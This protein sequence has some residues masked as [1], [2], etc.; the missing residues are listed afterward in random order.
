MQQGSVSKSLII[1]AVLFVGLVIAG[2][3]VYTAKI[4]GPK[5]AFETVTI[6]AQKETSSTSNPQPVS[7]HTQ[8][9]AQASATTSPEKVLSC[10]ELL[11]KDTEAKKI[12]YEPRT[13]LV[14][15]KE[16]V[17]FET[18]K[19]KMIFYGARIELEAEAKENYPSHRLLTLVVPEGQEFA[20]ICQIQKDATV[21][22]ASLNVLL[23]LHD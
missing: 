7:A 2:R 17:S 9:A 1:L 22:Y 11:K 10:P 12:D 8:T 21:R 19:E 23:N 6:P 4:T 16:D 15:F 14:G 3:Y 13:I 18:A 20:K 5:I